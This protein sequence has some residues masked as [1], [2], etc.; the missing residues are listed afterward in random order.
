MLAI[1][2]PVIFWISSCKDEPIEYVIDRQPVFSFRLDTFDIVTTDEVNIYEGATI[3]HVFEDSSEVLFQRFSLQAQGVTPSGIDYWF[4]VDFDSH[5]TGDATGTYRTEYDSLK[6]G[7]N[8]MRL[9]IDDNGEMIEFSI[10]GEVNSAYFQVDAQRKEE[11]IM[12]GI[13]GGVLFQDGEVKSQSV[14]IT[15]GL[16]K[17]IYY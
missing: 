3:L 5:A 9:I 2:L 7:I 14:L 8:D 6:G 12:K 16:F 11:R 10:T 15:D 1:S 17:D 4:V 13:F